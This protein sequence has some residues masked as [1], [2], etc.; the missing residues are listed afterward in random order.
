[1]VWYVIAAVSGG[2]ASVLSFV[3]PPGRLYAATGWA[4]A[5]LLWTLK[6]LEAM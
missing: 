5:S 6:A 3:E 4:I 1:M 2:L